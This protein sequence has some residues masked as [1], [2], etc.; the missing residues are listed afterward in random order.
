M[1]RTP[2]EIDKFRRE[3]LVSVRVQA[4]WELIG[5]VAVTG[6]A[7]SIV[8]QEELV[9]TIAIAVE[10][11]I[12]GLDCFPILI[13]VAEIGALGAR[14]RIKPVKLLIRL[15]AASS[16]S[17]VFVVVI[18]DHLGNVGWSIFRCLIDV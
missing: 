16:V 3:N 18:A 9:R 4:E 1:T 2:T 11:L 6:E 15:L 5:V 13:D 12:S 8:E 17:F 7:E 10:D 14:I